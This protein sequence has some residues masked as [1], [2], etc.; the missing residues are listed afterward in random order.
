MEIR[1]AKLEDAEEIVSNLWM[2]LAREMQDYSDREFSEDIREKA[3]EKRRETVESDE[4][5][6]FV[7]EDDGLVGLVS[8]SIDRE[9]GLFKQPG[10]AYVHDLYVEPDY[11]REGLA[12]NLMAKIE[13]WALKQGCELIEFSVDSPNESAIEFYRGEGYSEIRKKMRKKL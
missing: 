8:A 13:A 9:N 6:C 3:L 10:T 4:G 7:A 5:I 1:E 2:P 11:R 12:S